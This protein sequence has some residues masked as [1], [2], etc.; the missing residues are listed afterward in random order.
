MEPPKYGIVFGSDGSVLRG[1]HGTGLS[2]EAGDQFMQMALM[3]AIAKLMARKEKEIEKENRY[4][5]DDPAS[6][7]GEAAP[8]TSLQSSP[9]RKKK[10]KLGKF[11]QKQNRKRRSK[12]SFPKY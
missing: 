7:S 11:G 4:K 9:A 10:V 12:R 6:S 8:Q 5:P 1:T 2:S 3:S